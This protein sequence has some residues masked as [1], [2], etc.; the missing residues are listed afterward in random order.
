MTVRAR[1]RG[2]YYVVEVLIPQ[3]TLWDIYPDR[4]SAEKAAARARN[5][6]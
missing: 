4:E 3:G 2:D 6:D 5:R 1:K